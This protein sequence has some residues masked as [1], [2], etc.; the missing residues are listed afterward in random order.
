[1]R[2]T[3][4]ILITIIL[5]MQITTIII[6]NFKKIKEFRFLSNDFNNNRKINN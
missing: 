1:M 3:I 6:K 2:I 5:T 4:L